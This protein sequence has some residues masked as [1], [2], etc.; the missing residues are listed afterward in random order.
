[1]TLWGLLLAVLMVACAPQDSEALPTLAALNTPTRAA[2]DSGASAAVVP[3]QTSENESPPEVATQEAAYILVTPTNPPSKTPTPTHTP[4]QTATNTSEPT[5]IT[6]A[7]ATATALIPPTKVVPFITA[8]VSQPIERVCDSTWFFIEPKPDHCPSTI[9][10]T[11]QAVYQEF[12][13]GLMLWLQ[14]EDL[15][16]VLYD[17]FGGPAWESYEDEFEE[18]MLEEDETWPLP[19]RDD[20]FQP[21]RGFGMLWRGNPAVRAR[22]GWATEKWEVPYSS[23]VQIGE[24]ETIFLQDPYGGIVT[25]LVDQSDWQRYLGGNPTRL[26]L[27][28][29]PT[30]TATP[31]S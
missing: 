20:L 9:A 4:T 17:N 31:K 12:Q 25:L 26:E 8:V 15:I 10:T 11:S 6:T 7:T 24:D 28:L 13:H 19:P 22:I 16:Y 5:E 30:L 21:R 1:M 14:Q 18:G 23:T 2:S 29:I 27:E 3:L